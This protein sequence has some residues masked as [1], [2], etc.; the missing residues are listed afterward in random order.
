MGITF[1][2]LSSLD[3]FLPCRLCTY[4]LHSPQNS[5]RDWKTSEPVG[6]MSAPNNKETHIGPQ[7]LLLVALTE[8][9]GNRIMGKGSRLESRL[10]PLDPA[11]P[12]L[13][14]RFLINNE[15][16]SHRVVRGKPKIGSEKQS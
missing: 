6:D 11:S 2:G 13:G 14:L 7:H 5:L 4:R 9:P 16:A 3:L 8:L 1:K 15:T 12:H 10:Q